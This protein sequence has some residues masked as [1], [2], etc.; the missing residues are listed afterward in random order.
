M[1]T[2]NIDQAEM[3]LRHYDGNMLHF[4]KLTKTVSESTLKNVVFAHLCAGI[5]RLSLYGQN[6]TIRPTKIFEPARPLLTHFF[7]KPQTQIATI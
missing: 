1:R 3:P 5:W 4:T 2:F 7:S 6:G